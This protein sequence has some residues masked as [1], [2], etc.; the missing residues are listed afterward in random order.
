MEEYDYNKLFIV[1]TR[2]F[3]KIYR[4]WHSQIS[5]D[6]LKVTNENWWW[7]SYNEFNVKNQSKVWN[8]KLMN[9]TIQNLASEMELVCEK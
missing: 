4:Q 3:N 7:L 9:D 5:K 8:T 6:W 1:L 2:L